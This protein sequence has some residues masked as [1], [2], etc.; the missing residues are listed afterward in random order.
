MIVWLGD[1][2]WF[3]V[4][5]GH[6]VLMPWSLQVSLP[7]RNALFHHWFLHSCHSNPLSW[8]KHSGHQRRVWDTLMQPNKECFFDVSLSNTIKSTKLGK[9]DAKQTIQWYLWCQMRA[10]SA[11]LADLASSGPVWKD[12]QN[13]ARH[14]LPG[15]EGVGRWL[16]CSNAT[17]ITIISKN[18][19]T[20]ELPVLPQGH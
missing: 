1:S 16:M 19:D 3:V 13:F 18:P 15:H 10:S 20:L 7:W 6:L 14:A 12:C 17:H 9:R 11:F 5:F 4:F 8:S 2:I